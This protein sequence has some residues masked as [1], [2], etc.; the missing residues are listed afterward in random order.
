MVD[1][2]DSEGAGGA[3]DGGDLLCDCWKT[4][5]DRSTESSGWGTAR[6]GP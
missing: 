4:L 2:E 6:P 1:E 3:A 5:G